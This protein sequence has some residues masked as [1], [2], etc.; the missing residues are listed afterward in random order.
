[1]TKIKVFDSILP[2]R[3]C[4]S[5]LDLAL[6]KSISSLHPT[7][8]NSLD[9]SHFCCGHLVDKVDG[10]GASKRLLQLNDRA[11]V[12]HLFILPTDHNSPWTDFF[13]HLYQLKV[14]Q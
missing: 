3:R 1:M 5:S 9:I 13:Q 10:P 7:L 4:S 8:T 11:C 2:L 6:T 12:K 14:L